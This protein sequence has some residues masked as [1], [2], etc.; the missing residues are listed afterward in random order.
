MNFSS[1][2][3]AF[4]VASLAATILATTPVGNPLEQT[5]PLASLPWLLEAATA[6]M[7]AIAAV[8]VFLTITQKKT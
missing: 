4:A 7:W 2:A 5:Q 3:L 8:A 1:M 6:T